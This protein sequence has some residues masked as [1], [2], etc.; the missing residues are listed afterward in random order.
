MKSVVLGLSGGVDSSTAAAI[1][2]DAG[3]DVTGVYCLMHGHSGEGIADARAVA[4]SVGIKFDTVDL[5]GQFEKYV[6][7]DFLD[8]YR[9][10]RTPNPCTVCNPNVKFRSLCDYADRIGAEFVAT[11]HYAGTGCE[12]GRYFIRKSEYKDQS[13]M[14]W[15]LTQSQI[16]RLLLPLYNEYKPDVRK[17]AESYGIP[18]AEKPDSLDLCFVP[19]GDY[20]SFIERRTG[21]FPEG[22]FWLKEENRAVGRHKGIIHYTVGQRKNLGISLGVPA[23]VCG[24]DIAN[25]RVIISRKD[26]T[27][28]TRLSCSGAVFQALDPSVGSF[29]A[30]VKIRYAHKGARGKVTLTETGFTVDFYE[31]QR[32]V[33]PGQ[34][35][36]CYLEDRIL[37]GGVINQEE[38]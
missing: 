35:A 20:A 21:P 13:Y 36:V 34:S 5:T 6:I 15:A 1:L 38:I 11:G 29:D 23:Y 28:C 33:T 2:R 25:N 7:S 4:E 22:D 31:P 18:V 3:Y 19:D 27:D 26:V 10:G 14:L 30:D 12:N 16:S 8:C 24:F 37:C 17:R 9:N 32:A